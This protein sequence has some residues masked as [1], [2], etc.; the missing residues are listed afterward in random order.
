VLAG[1]PIVDLKVLVVD[2]SYHDVDSSDMAFKIAASMGF[3]KGFM[4]CN[5]ILLEPIMNVE[6]NVPE[7]MTGDIIGDLNSRRGRVLGMDQGVGGQVVKAKVPKAEMLRYASD[8]T[9]ITS[10]R[11]MFTMEFDHYEEV[12][13][14]LSEKII[15]A[16]KTEK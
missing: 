9:S 10:G 2:G 13:A 12:P 5:P 16:A 6:V 4:E 7:D 3:K 8:L 1:Y 14:H 15:A 11:G